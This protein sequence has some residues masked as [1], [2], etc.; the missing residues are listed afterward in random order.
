MTVHTSGSIRRTRRQ[1]DRKLRRGADLRERVEI[2]L[3]I[4]HEGHVLRFHF[5]RRGCCRQGI[6]PFPTKSRARGLP[7]VMWLRAATGCS[8]TDLR[9][10]TDLLMPTTD[11]VSGGDRVFVVKLRPLGELMGSRRCG[12]H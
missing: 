2:A 11:K 10:L 4:M 9:K 1:L 5:D 12:G 7:T 8:S 3:N 6:G